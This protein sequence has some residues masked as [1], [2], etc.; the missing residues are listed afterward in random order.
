MLQIRALVLLL[1]FLCS[2]SWTEV[3]DPLPLWL[4]EDAFDDE[5][6]PPF[7]IDVV[8]PADVQTAYQLYKNGN[9]KE[10]MGFLKKIRNLNL[11][12]GRLDFF[13]F[14][15]AECN[16]MLKLKET[17]KQ[18]YAHIT[19]RFAESDKNAPSIYR[20]IEYAVDDN[21]FEAVDSLHSMFSKKFSGHTLIS[22]V[23][24]AA[25]RSLYMQKK[26]ENA[27]TVLNEI[28]S[29]SAIT[30]PAQFLTA[31]CLIGL[32]EYQK[33]ISHLD[34]VIQNGKKPELSSEAKILAGDIYY[35]LKNYK[36]ALKYYSEVPV[37]AS[38]HTY[39]VIKTAK[40]FYDMKNYREAEKLGRDFLKKGKRNDYFF[41]MATILEQVYS[42]QKKER[43]AA[44]I[45]KIIH[46]QLIDSRTLFAVYE[47]RDRL[48]DISKSLQQMEFEAIRKG[49]K[50]LKA[51]SEEKKKK[52]ES[53]QKKCTSILN[54]LDITTDNDRE[55]LPHWA[56]RRYI[57]MVRKD[58]GL[59]ED[60][61]S[62]IKNEIEME[63][64]TETN[65][66]NARLDSL[67]QY[68][69]QLTSRYNQLEHEYLLVEN[70]CFAPDER[71]GSQQEEMQ[72]RFVDWSFI[73]Y[74]D[75]NNYLVSLAQNMSDLSKLTKIDTLHADSIAKEI[76][77]I[78]TD[79]MKTSNGMSEDRLRLIEHINTMLEVYP[80]CK[81]NGQ[82]LF[83]LAE[84]KYDLAGEKFQH[85]L[86][87]YEA[88]ISSGKD[89]SGL[90]F[91][92]YNL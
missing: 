45:E 54:Q 1:S 28:S 63:A 59:Y 40:M 82:V 36:N 75:R 69:K 47:E 12:D 83:R 80:K 88:A 81:Y 61:I 66:E 79:Y 46:H 29:G 30:V 53:L 51:F 56:E 23:H 6:I 74:Q 89:S 73:K 14:I 58:M 13:I 57:S 27:I 3:S 33:A 85:A 91:P 25:A 38:R 22:V 52:N 24:Y 41:E 92:D 39:V 42:A 15:I 31:L 68:Q 87:E 50:N 20:L 71:N 90:E 55:T 19:K 4:M 70:E 35:L 76:G 2:V 44:K 72:I 9:Y 49:D 16:R 5:Y 10:A 21:D 18:E 67:E 84:L 32:K 7:D 8:S 48:T 43:D 62:S 37:N 65:Q 34:L 86:R 78:R 11:P 60:S 64:S 77:K 17:A 26:Y